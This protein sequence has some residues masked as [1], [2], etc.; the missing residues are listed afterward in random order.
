M[1]RLHLRAGYCAWTHLRHTLTLSLQS[2]L[3]HNYWHY[4]SL[5]M[6]MIT[7]S[8]S[9][10]FDMCILHI[11]WGLVFVT[12]LWQPCSVC[13][14]TAGRRSSSPALLVSAWFSQD[15]KTW[16]IW[17]NR[18]KTESRAARAKENRITRSLKKLRLKSSAKMSLKSLIKLRISCQQGASSELADAGPKTA[19][20]GLWNVA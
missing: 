9:S 2:T 15:R 16:E 6:I 19:V 18:K 13:L 5:Y 4:T 3:R 14:S 10:V 17:E 12:T 20:V 7:L 1:H 11:S 8:I